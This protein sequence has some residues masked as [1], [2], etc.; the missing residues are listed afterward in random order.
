VDTDG[1][2]AGDSCDSNTCLGEDNGD[3]LFGDVCNNCISQANRSQS[4]LDNYGVGDACDNCVSFFKTLIKMI[5]ISM[6][7]R[8]FVKLLIFAALEVIP[9]M[10]GV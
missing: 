10:K 3:L 8:M 9:I 1:D 5:P 6:G 7:L 2:G 4:D